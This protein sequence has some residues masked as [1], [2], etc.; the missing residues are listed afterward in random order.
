MT[1]ENPVF[2]TYVI[3]ASILVLKVMAQGWMTV[4][5]MLK[6]GGG[7]MSP[8]DE[9]KGLTN[10]EPR[11]G[12]LELDDYVDRSRRIHHNDIENIPLFLVAGILFV[13]TEP[14]LWLAQVLFYGYVGTRLI[15]TVV[16]L[17]AMSHEVRATLWTPG[18]LIV[19]A[20]A[21]YSLFYAIA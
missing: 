12:Q 14:P 19:I 1:F 17:R 18:S 15:H 16:Y 2:A 7:F 9:Q 8:E 6:V 11:A 5:R 4:Q 10:P 21:G 20:L 13:L 3:A